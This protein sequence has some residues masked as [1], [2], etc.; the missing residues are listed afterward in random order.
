MIL[1]NDHSRDPLIISGICKKKKIPVFFI[2]HGS[3]AGETIKKKPMYFNFAL[4][5]GEDQKNKIESAIPDSKVYIIG[6]PMSDCTSSKSNRFC[7]NYSSLSP[8]KSL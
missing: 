6:R 1:T 8:Y 4:V 7:K 3:F 5:A 2:P